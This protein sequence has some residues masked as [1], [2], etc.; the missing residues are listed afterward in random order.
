MTAAE[1]SAPCT[2]CFALVGH[3]CLHCNRKFDT[4]EDLLKHQ[5]KRQHIGGHFILEARLDACTRRTPVRFRDVDA[6]AAI[7]EQLGSNVLDDTAEVVQLDAAL[8][9]ADNIAA[10][11]TPAEHIND[12]DEI[13]FDDENSD[14]DVENASTHEDIAASCCTSSSDVTINDVFQQKRKRGEETSV[15]KRSRETPVDLQNAPTWVQQLMTPGTDKHI[16]GISIRAPDWSRFDC[17]CGAKNL[18]SGGSVDTIKKHR[19]KCNYCMKVPEEILSLER[20][21]G[22][23][24]NAIM[25]ANLPFSVVENA[26]FRALVGA[27]RGREHLSVPSRRT[28]VRSFDNIC[29]RVMRELKAAVAAAASPISITFDLWTDRQTRGYVGVTGHFFDENLILRAPL[30]GFAFVPKSNIEGHTI[31]RIVDSVT[32]ILI[33]VLGDDWK[34]KVNCIVTDGAKNVTGASRRLGE[35]RRCFQHGLQLFLKHFCATQRDVATAMASCNYLAKLCGLSQKFRSAVGTIPAGVV[36]RWNSFIKTAR[37][38]LSKRN[39]LA[40]YAF[41][42]NIDRKLAELLKP[43]VTQLHFSGFNLLHDMLQLLA[44]LTDITTNE[45]AELYITSS[46]VIPQLI[47]A[48]KRMDT[49]LAASATGDSLSGAI[50]NPAKVASWKDL[51]TLLW[52]T[53]VAEFVTDDLFLTATMLDGRWQLG[54]SLPQ[55]LVTKAGDCLRR[56]MKSVF[57]RLE[58][59][60]KIAA[61]VIAAGIANQSANSGGAQVANARVASAHAVARAAAALGVSV[62]AQPQAWALPPRPYNDVETE[63]KQLINAICN[64]ALEMHDDPMQIFK[65]NNLL[66]AHAVA[67]DVLSVPCGGAPCERPFSIAPRITFIRNNKIALESCF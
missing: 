63:S 21:R 15:A 28:I 37:V 29:D 16:A 62:E 2:I 64:G 54:A 34:S 18:A 52:D 24:V 26:E 13:E 32:A 59:E 51:V 56:R 17:A 1:M 39:E 35:S 60:R 58:S 11:D 50:C 44:P 27:G 6:D 49:I 30:L 67:L 65:N 57:D 22:L 55:E 45:E 33:D 20:F 7:D 8:A 66:L 5:R 4:E 19:A 23:L 12:I 3:M 47:A 43:H 38:V 42:A 61:R 9:D 10:L 53:Y 31:E 14:D 36:T 48:K 46:S 25:S 41:G 40:N